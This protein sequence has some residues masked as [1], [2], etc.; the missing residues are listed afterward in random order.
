MCGLGFVSN[1]KEKKEIKV[2]NIDHCNDVQIC[3]NI[4]I[5]KLSVL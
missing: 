3:L 4:Q 2:G 1:V 5:D